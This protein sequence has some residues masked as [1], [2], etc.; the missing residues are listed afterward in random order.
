MEHHHHVEEGD[1]NGGGGG[2]GSPGSQEGQNLHDLQNYLVTFNKEIGEPGDVLSSMDV[3]GEVGDLYNPG[4]S[5]A[6]QDGGEES[7]VGEASLGEAG[8]FSAGF[9]TEHQ[10]TSIGGYSLNYF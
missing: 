6:L 2:S 9:Y 10:G 5:S 3:D 8:Q 7:V 4:G 1:N